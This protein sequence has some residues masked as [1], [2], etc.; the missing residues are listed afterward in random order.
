MVT[1]PEKALGLPDSDR[2]AEN[3]RIHDEHGME[4]RKR[5]LYASLCLEYI[6][7]HLRALEMGRT[8]ADGPVPKGWSFNENIEYLVKK[9]MMDAE[10]GR[11][12]HAFRDVRNAFLHTLEC[13]DSDELERVEPAPIPLL[14]NLAAQGMAQ[15]PHVSAGTRRQRID[16]GLNILVHL[17]T[18][19]CGRMIGVQ[20]VKKLGAPFPP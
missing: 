12:F 6:A 17:I 10:A 11:Q 19:E 20:A 2:D 14:I 8:A 4:L 5:I 3:S 1:I 13:K 9:Q 18:E 7:K 16:L 15:H